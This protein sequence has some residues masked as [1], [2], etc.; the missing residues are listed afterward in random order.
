M[1]ARILVVDNTPDNARTLEAKLTQEYYQVATAFSGED[2]I[3]RATDWHPDLILLDATMPGMDGNATCRLL[4]GNSATQHIPVVMITTL[5]GARDPVTGAEGGADDFLTRPLDDDLLF[6]RVR[7][8]VRL[9]RLQ[10]EWQMRDETAQ[11]LG[12][13]RD[14]AQQIQIAGSRALI[15]DDRAQDAERILNA[16]NEDGF[17][18]TCVR[19]TAEASVWLKKVHFDLIVMSL[20]LQDEDAL[21]FASRLRS[22]DATREI[23][24]VLVAEGGQKDRLLRGFDLGANDYV[25]YPMD[26]LELRARTRNQIRRKFIQSRM[27][28]DFDRAL[29]LALI[30]PLTGLY[31]RRYLTRHLDSQLHEADATRTVGPSIMMIDLD[32]FKQVNDRWGHVAGD[33]VLLAISVALRV[34]VRVF[35]TVARAGG[36]EFVV[37]MPGTTQED[38]MNVAERLRQAIASIPCQI[39]P[40]VVHTQTVSIGVASYRLG[41]GNSTDLLRRADEALYRAKQAGKNRVELAG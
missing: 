9:K 28:A 2:I 15:I 33:S 8:L 21:R 7:S 18:G 22:E 20:A 12:I 25:F 40:E 19:S 39:S 29:E 1:T 23:P 10:D 30:D 27:R 37:L 32:D 3:Q 17:L 6:A 38:A 5:S 34:H 24:M 31:N 26:P 16:L 11:S 35:D 14:T 13:E 36:E 4:K 41:E